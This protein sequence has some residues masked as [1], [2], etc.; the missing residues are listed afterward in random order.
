MSQVVQPY[1]FQVDTLADALPGRLK[2]GQAPTWFGAVGMRQVGCR[3]WHRPLKVQDPE[4]LDGS[5][6]RRAVVDDD[7]NRG[8]AHVPH[9]LFV[10]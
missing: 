10:M 3:R 7:T 5:P 4:L 1:V 8:C 6:S 2:V 9:M